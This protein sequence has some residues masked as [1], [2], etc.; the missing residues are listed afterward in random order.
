MGNP[1]RELDNKATSMEQKPI[2]TTKLEFRK[3]HKY[4]PN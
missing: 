3:T 2:A 4:Q 1:L